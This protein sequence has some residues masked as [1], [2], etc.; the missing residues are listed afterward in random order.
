MGGR[1]EEK[2]W[3]RDGQGEDGGS[4]EEGIG[5]VRDIWG[6]WGDLGRVVVCQMCLVEYG[7]EVSGGEF[8]S[9]F[10]EVWVEHE[11]A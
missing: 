1:W 10:G 2:R 4:E 5:R 7:L 6:S 8:R 3:E 9:H 11:K